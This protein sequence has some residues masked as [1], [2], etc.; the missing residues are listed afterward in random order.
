MNLIER[1]LAGLSAPDAERFIRAL[2]APNQRFARAFH[3]YWKHVLQQN[4]PTARLNT[5]CELSQV[6]DKLLAN[7]GDPDMFTVGHGEGAAYQP[8]GIF[9]YRPLRAHAFGD[10][11]ASVVAR[12]PLATQCKG[13]LGIA[14]C[15]GILDAH[16]GM[17]V[18]KTMFLSIARK[19]QA[20]QHGQLFFFTS[21]HRLEGLYRRFG[22]EFPDSLAVPDSKHLVGM[23]DL[24]RCENRI[25]IDQLECAI[26]RESEGEELARAA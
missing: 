3:H 6:A 8:I 23:Y 2:F 5:L 1:P 14:H 19:A 12:G 7:L 22:M 20:E 9:G 21:D 25:R 10:R 18:L 15:V 26:E 24:T 4:E 17:R 16:A 13:E 11:I